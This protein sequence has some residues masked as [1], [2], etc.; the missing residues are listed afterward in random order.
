MLANVYEVEC[1]ND[2]K[3]MSKLKVVQITEGKNLQDGKRGD[4]NACSLTS[5]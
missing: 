1:S 5:C 4:F 3:T 2:F